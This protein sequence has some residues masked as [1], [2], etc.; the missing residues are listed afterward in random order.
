MK[1]HST[2]YLSSTHYEVITKV[3]L[4]KK[5]KKERRKSRKKTEK[6]RKIKTVKLLPVFAAGLRFPRESFIGH[7]GRFYTKDVKT[8]SETA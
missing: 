6:K 8:S 3:Y 5:K 2:K 1:T 7:I 4:E